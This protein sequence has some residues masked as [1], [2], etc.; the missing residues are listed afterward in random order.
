MR[1]SATRVKKHISPRVETTH[2]TTRGRFFSEQKKKKINAKIICHRVRNTL[3]RIVE[4]HRTIGKYNTAVCVFLF[5][6][7]P[8]LLFYFTLCVGA[9]IHVVGYTV[10]NPPWRQNPTALTKLKETT[11]CIYIYVCVYTHL[12]TSETLR[13]YE[14]RDVQG[15]YRCK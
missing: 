15:V 6:I 10:G 4:M 5:Q 8:S 1:Y 7:Y 13:F 3:K 9:C 14:I 2:I 12:Y 11:A